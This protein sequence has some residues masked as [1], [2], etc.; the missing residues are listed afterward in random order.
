M[1]FILKKNSLKVNRLTNGAG[2]T[3]YPHAKE[4]SWT[5]SSHRTQKWT[6]NGSQRMLDLKL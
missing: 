2:I 3:G 6:P 5:L 4:E 1:Y